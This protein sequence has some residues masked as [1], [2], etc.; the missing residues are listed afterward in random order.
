MSVEIG[1]DAPIDESAVIHEA[2]DRVRRQRE[3]VE[4]SRECLRCRNVASVLRGAQQALEQA[5]AG[6]GIEMLVAQPARLER[7]SPNVRTGPR[8]E[9]EVTRQH[10][11]PVSPNV[12]L[13]V[14]RRS[15]PLR[16]SMSARAR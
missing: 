4:T 15:Q 14:A 11:N 2:S 7:C 9:D 5:Q 12:P 13:G 10:V 16:V 1:L 3:F 6:L 8:R